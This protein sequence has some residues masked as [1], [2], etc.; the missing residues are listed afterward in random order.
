MNLLCQGRAVG[1]G[2]SQGVVYAALYTSADPRRGASPGETVRFG[3][4]VAPDGGA[5]RGCAYLPVQPLVEVGEILGVEG[6]EYF[7]RQ[8]WYRIRADSGETVNGVLHLRVGATAAARS[9]R[10]QILVGVPDA[11]G[12]KLVRTG[13][14]AADPVPLRPL[15]PRGLRIAT[16]PGRPGTVNVLSAAPPGSTAVSVTQPRAG[17]AQLSYDG[18]VTYT[19]AAG[20]TGYDRFEYMVATAAAGQQTSHVNVFVGSLEH[21]PGAFPQQPADAAVRPW[22]WPELS[23]EMP[24]P[25]PDQTA[26]NR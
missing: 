4:S 6:L 24:W 15:A 20:F 3:L 11:S 16:A 26:R 10:P 25:R 23:G 5:P 14:L 17:H 19:P 18:S 22:Q 2:P 12:L 1:A 7:P 8:R 9:I 21:I 13:R